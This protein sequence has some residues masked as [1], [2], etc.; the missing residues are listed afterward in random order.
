MDLSFSCLKRSLRKVDHST[1]SSDEVKNEWR[2]TS[3]PPI[4]I[5]GADKNN[6]TF[7]FSFFFLFIR[8]SL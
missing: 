5:Y 8:S 1:P 3:I 6:V 7:F 4:C 2:Y